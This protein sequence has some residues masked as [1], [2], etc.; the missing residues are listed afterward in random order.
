MNLSFFHHHL[1]KTAVGGAI[2]D[3]L[4]IPV[5]LL[6]AAWLA[7]IVLSA[8]AG[9]TKAVLAGGVRLALLLV[10]YQL[11]EAL[12]RMYLERG[13]ARA[14]QRCRQELY[15]RFLSKPLSALYSDDRGQWKECLTDD[16]DMACDR[17]LSVFPGIC[18]G[19]LTAAAYFVYIG[20][21]SLLMAGLLALIS[22]IQ[23]I[24]PLLV[25]GYFEKNYQDT[26]DIEARLT[27]LT[28]EAHHGFAV[29]K[30]YQ[31]K[32]WYLEKLKK[33]H[34]AYQKIGSTGI[35]TSTAEGVLN[36]FVAMVLKY[37]ACALA[38]ILAL[39]QVVSLDAGV[40]AIALSGS[41]FAAVNTVFSSITRLAV[42][43]QARKRL[44]DCMADIPEEETGAIENTQI[45]LQDISL[46]FADRKLFDHVRMCFPKEG[47]CLIRGANGAGKSTL[48]RLM[49]GLIHADEGEVRLGDVPPDA[50]S[51]AVFVRD[52]FYLPQE[53]AAFAF[54]PRMFYEM[55]DETAVERVM[56]LAHR[57]GLED[58]QLEETNIRDLSGGERKKVFL[59][60]AFAA[61][62]K[63]LLLDEPTNALDEDSKRLLLS[64][65]QKRKGLT[66]IISHDPAL[67]ALPAQRY[68]IGKGG[69]AYAQS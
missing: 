5:S 11:L 4:R 38:G 27:D 57:F 69:I 66:L 49:A 51:D 36:D 33:L 25:K 48:F 47:I 2:L 6:S 29:L 3:L 10:G 39:R 67:N 54:P 14:R 34:R 44:A 68:S 59:A 61:N 22:L 15:R 41:F 17:I 63:I 42:T 7:D 20:R 40:E 58:R 52:L 16:F 26:R 28:V 31:L 50:L 13:R 64:E 23:L 21:G 8:T 56:E 62:P 45:Q 19:L 9:D 12:G 43:K 37:G 32:E 60:L 55:A 18:T 1:R 35:Y 65:L 53:D 24:P 30:L 46:S